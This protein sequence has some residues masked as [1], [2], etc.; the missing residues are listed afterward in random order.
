[1]PDW[2]AAC[3]RRSMPRRRACRCAR[4]LRHR[5]HDAAA[6]AGRSRSAA[7]SCQYIDVERAASTPERFFHA[8]F[9]ELAVRRS[10][11]AA[12]ARC[13]RRQRPRRLRSHAGVL[14][15]RAHARRPAGDVP[16]RRGARAAHVRELP[17]P[18]PRAARAGAG[19]CRQPQPLRLHEPLCG[20]R[21]PGAARR[22][23][24]ASRWCTCRRCRCRTSRRCCRRARAPRSTRDDLATAVHALADGRAAYVRALGE[25][26]RRR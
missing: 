22:G 23:R 4:R 1:M 6:R 2:S 21:A 3:S 8:V 24:R 26:R 14:P 25:S 17:R 11:R 19:D 16:A 12:A 7:P 9:T 5:P 10:R 15:A 20:P 18:A 13:R